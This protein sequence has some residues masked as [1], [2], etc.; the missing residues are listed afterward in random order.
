MNH[1]DQSDWTAI[2]VV[3]GFLLGLLCYAI[4]YDR[5]VKDAGVEARGVISE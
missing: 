3:V 4:G 1:D 2:A 5:G